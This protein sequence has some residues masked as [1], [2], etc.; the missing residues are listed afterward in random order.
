[1]IN[2]SNKRIL[3]TGGTGHL[4]AA[5]IHYL[6]SEKNAK[7]AAIRAFYLKGSPA[8]ALADLP[9]VDLHEGNMLHAE[10]VR[11]AVKDIE[12]IFHTAGSTSFD[13]R[14]KK[15]QWLVNV[16]GTRNLLEAARQSPTFE[17]MV[18]TS[19]VNVLAVPA[20]AGSIGT[21]ETCDPYTAAE[22]LHA[23]NSAADALQFIEQARSN[24]GPWLE[25][26]G[27]GY[28]DSKL[29]AQELVNYYVQQYQLPV[30]SILPGTMF[31]PYD[32][33]LGTGLYLLSLYHNQM[34]VVTGGG[35]PLAHV[36][37]VAEGQVLAMEKAAPGTR[38]ILSGPEEDN[39]YLREMCGIIV[40]VL[41][42]R[43]PEKKF[44]KPVLVVPNA[45]AMLAAT[46]GERY[47]VWFNRP[48]LL[49]KAAAKPGLY[50]Q[51]YSSKKAA[52]ELGY[53]P[54]RSFKQA[55]SDMLH[56]YITHNLLVPHTR[57][58]DKR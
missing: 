51:F 24:R 57:Y 5:I 26:I 52:E 20:P 12:I 45:L 11:E 32:H 23:F 8:D 7:P 2:W 49:S 44:R 1:M 55:V 4:G 33:L 38:Y 34:P 54:K 16:E 31:G 19:T 43:F 13:S 10:E 29:A 50:A 37:D 56:Y 27:L 36:L 46:V 9:G 47:A 48:M 21:I 42:E 53:E 35:L 22:K 30:V 40:D 3:V 39:R 17:K 41:R 18:Y 14:Q 15:M 6:V 28:Y 25:R 58:V